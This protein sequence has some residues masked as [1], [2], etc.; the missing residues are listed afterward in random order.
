MSFENLKYDENRL[1]KALKEVTGKINSL[2]TTKIYLIN[3]LKNEERS[4][5]YGLHDR[6]GSIS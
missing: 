5:Q 1:R 3:Q 4:F 6:D 2:R